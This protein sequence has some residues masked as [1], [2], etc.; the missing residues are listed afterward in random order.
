MKSPLINS[1]LRCKK[2]LKF[3]LKIIE[4]FKFFPGDLPSC[5]QNNF[6]P[7][8]QCT[9]L[10]TSFAITQI[11]F[12]VVVTIFTMYHAI[13]KT[14]QCIEISSQFRFDASLRFS[15]KH[16]FVLVASREAS[17]VVGIVIRRISKNRLENIHEYRSCIQIYFCTR[18]INHRFWRLRKVSCNKNP[19]CAL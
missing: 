18:T 15:R 3:W 2:L 9:S 11:R 8:L 16:F 14:N 17:H 12:V 1:G 4:H 7:S 10:F 5:T 13:F 6:F 19:L